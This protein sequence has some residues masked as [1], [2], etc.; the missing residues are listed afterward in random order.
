MAENIPSKPP[1]TIYKYRDWAND[2]HKRIL[3][4]NEIYLSSPG[5]FNDPYDCKIATHF[6]SLDNPDK[7]KQYIE[8]RRP[9]SDLDEK[10]IAILE[11]R[12]NN[13]SEYWDMFQALEFTMIDQHYGVLSL[14]ARWDSILMWSH[15]ANF[16]KGF[17]VGFNEE[18]MRTSGLFDCG[19]L[20]K[21]S[22]DFPLIDPHANE[23]DKM[24]LQTQYKAKNWEYEEEYRLSKLFYPSAPTI[25]QRVK[26]INS[27]F[28]EEVILGMGISHQYSFEIQAIC[29]TKNIPVS[30]IKRLPFK[31]EIVKVPL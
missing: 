2:N 24:F 28:I 4:E 11:E 19:G 27:E 13:I 15:Y 12:L 9:E 31:F 14:S 7:V 25:N 3:T 30:Q 21:Y 20:V 16:H 17:C 23:I 26:K 6:L 10:G 29:K 5:D 18:K 8:A 1:K 22:D